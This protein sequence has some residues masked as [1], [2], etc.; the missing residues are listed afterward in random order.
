M[1]NTSARSSQRKRRKRRKHNS[2]QGNTQGL[3]HGDS[4][5]SGA[6]VRKLSLGSFSIFGK[7]KNHEQIA[8]GPQKTGGN[9][10]ANSDP[11]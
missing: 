4:P 5:F 9:N 6:K 11:G 8:V 1:R 3:F 7:G 2:G 10:A